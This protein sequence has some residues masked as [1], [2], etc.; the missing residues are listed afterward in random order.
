MWDNKYML[1]SKKQQ[2]DFKAL[3]E[4]G[5]RLDYKKGEM[6]IRANETPTV[7]FLI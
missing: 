2:K 5:R 3:F 6:I 4:K 7:V 1:A